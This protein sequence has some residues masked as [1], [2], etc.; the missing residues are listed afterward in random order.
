MPKI[1]FILKRREDY[2]ATLHSHLGLS[3]G[4]FNSASFMRDML[5]KS[6]IDSKLVVVTDNNDIDREVT[7]YKP[8]HVIIEALWVVPSK[9]IVLQKLHPSVK[10]VIRIHSEMPFMAGEGMAMDWVGDY[11]TFKNVIVACNTPRM[12]EEVR[13]FLRIKNDWSKKTTCERVIY[14]P[15]YYPQFYRPFIE[16]NKDKDTI[17]VGCF[18]AIRLLKNHLLQAYGALEF[19][20]KIGKKLRFHINAGRIEM[21]GEPAL[22]NLKGLFQHLQPKGH[23]LVNHMWTPREQFL[24]LC[25]QMDIGLQVSFSETFNIVSAD[26]ISQGI[27]VVGSKEVPWLTSD[28]FFEHEFRADPTSSRDIANKMLYA[29]K[30]PEKNVKQ[31]QKSLTKYTNKT[32]QIWCKYFN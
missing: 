18:G 2:N 12:L 1:L 7:A 25:S 13:L 14:L 23:E 6:R 29:Y 17:D 4:L 19:A 31:G 11:S 8:T 28:W 21:K 3:T 27:P 26:Y 32:E 22:N 24:Q 20:D 15:N 10:W 9:F 16:F 30:N 5:N